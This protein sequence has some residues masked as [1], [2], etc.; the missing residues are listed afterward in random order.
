MSL[1]SVV[2]LGAI[3]VVLALGIAYTTFGVLKFDPFA[4]F[5]TAELILPTSGGLGPR[6]PVLLT[7]VEVGKVT[8]VRKVASGVQAQIRI[9]HEY[10]IPVA[11]TLR[12]ENLSALGEP[13]LLFIPQRDQ[14][15]FIED[16]QVIDTRAL[17]APVSIQDLSLRLV[18]LID[19][20]DPT[21]VRSLVDGFSTAI[22]GTA[23]EV[24]RLERSTKLLAATLLSRSDQIR[25]L[26]ADLQSIS[27]DIAWVGP[28]LQAAGSQWLKLAE[29][30]DESI[31]RAG[32]G[33]VAK[34]AAE[35]FTTGDGLVPFLRQLNEFLDKVGPGIAELAPV[36]QPLVADMTNAAGGIDI[37]T[38]ITQAVNSVGADGAVHLRIDLK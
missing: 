12:I 15:P 4:K 20:L 35:D 2:S 14:G 16:D 36:L 33:L 11:S 24:P 10:R 37:G 31:D 23:S 29:R 3:V 6:S 22:E 8:S 21:I 27:T 17:Q 34:R 38:L 13:Y 19:Q 25:Q 32:H 18:E 9:D 30:L 1:R 26:L 28:S 5:V 7:G